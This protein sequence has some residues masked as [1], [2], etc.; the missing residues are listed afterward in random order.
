MGWNSWNE[1]KG[2]ISESLIESVADAMVASG[3]R[4]AGYTYVNIDDTWS[5]K[6]GRAA[7]GSLQADPAKFPDGISAVAAYV[8]ADQMKLGIYGDR[9]TATCGGYP[10][11]Q[12]Y[13]TQ[14]AATFAGWGVDYLKYDNCNA[15]LDVETQYKT[16]A[17][18]LAATAH[19]F[20]FSLCA[21]QFYEWGVTTGNLWR[22]TSDI[23][24]SWSSIL[25]NA[26]NNRT[27]AAYA[28][29]N[30][31]NDPDMLEVGVSDDLLS[32]GVNHTE[33][34]SHFSLWAIQSAPLIMGNDPTQIAKNPAILTMLTNKEIIALDQDALGL[35]GVE[36]WESSDGNLS[37]WA[38]PLNASGARGVVLLNAGP[39]PADIGFT[40]PQIGLAGGSA[41][42]R[43]LVAQADLGTFDDSYT[44]AAIPSHG[45]A[46]LKV[47]GT[48]P[49]RPSGTQ[50]LS[51]SHLDLR[52]QRP[53]PGREG[54]EQRLLGARRRHADLT[55]GDGL[56]Q[57]A[58]HGRTGLG[59]LSP[60]Q[61]LHQL[62]RHRRRRRLGRR[63]GLGGVSGLAQDDKDVWTKLHDSGTVTGLDGQ[64]PAIDTMAVD[65]TGMRRLKLSHQ[66]PQ[67]RV[68]GSGQLG[69]RPNRLRE[70]ARA[71]V[72]MIAAF[73]AARRAGGGE[74]APGRGHHGRRRRREVG[75][76]QR[77]DCD[78]RPDGAGALLRRPLRRKT[79]C[80]GGDALADRRRPP[81]GRRPR[82]PGGEAEPH[83]RAHRAARPADRRR[84]GRPRQRSAARLRR[85]LSSSS[86]PDLFVP[87]QG[88]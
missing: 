45:S 80:A 55:S 44:I 7:D 54:H 67:R 82:D 76:A 21:W 51:D 81:A 61:G 3:L 25:A 53:R 18:A 9:G 49:P 58:R 85:R 50:Y 60:Q 19:P 34:Q 88:I 52:G 33:Y 59:H 83:R 87:H 63:P 27:Y 73:R 24:D 31:W 35:Q 5:N 20:V 47:T 23:T 74:R 29:P 70:V 6:A 8:H 79:A 32:Y 16:M 46:T 22:T 13:E 57:G 56:H 69:Q 41:A 30:G 71:R 62:H 38:K 78:C 77:A 26:M 72:R 42:V 28:G 15:T 65:L 66:R 1:F 75:V 12:G 40:L 37:V 4:D 14:D 17:A 68:V 10:G 36:V 84:A 39:D 86:G 48:E 2:S 11:S 64:N 43:D